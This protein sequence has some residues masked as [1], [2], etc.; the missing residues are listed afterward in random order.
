MNKQVRYYLS[1][2]ALGMGGSTI[3]LLMYIRY[4]FYDPM[5]QALGC[6][7]AQLGALTTISTVAGWVFT[8]PNGLMADKFDSKKLIILALMINSGCSFFFAT[9]MGSMGYTSA[10]ITWFG[11]SFSVGLGYWPSLMKFINTLAGPENAGKSFSTYYAIYGIFAACVNVVEI[12]VGNMVGFKGT[13]IVIGIVTLLCAVLDVFVL[14]NAEA[15]E[16]RIAAEQGGVPVEKLDDEPKKEKQKMSAADI[17]TMIKWPGFWYIGVIY[18]FTYTV[19][20]QISYYNP[21]LINVMGLDSTLSSTF[22]TIR[23]YLF[24]LWCPLGGILAD[25]VFKATW[26]AFIP[27]FAIS[28]V[29]LTGTLF[30]KEGMNPMIAAVYSLLPAIVIMPLYSITNSCLRELHINPAILGTTIAVSGLMGGPVDGLW[31]IIFGHWIDK[32]GN[33]GFTYIFMFLAADCILG[34][35]CALGIGHHD[36][37]CREGKR[38]QLLKGQERPEV[39]DW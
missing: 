17:I 6:T 38:V 31:P 3:W 24:M 15:R 7:N 34:I 11:L 29:L 30:F 8:V 23:T 20:A 27:L 18:L 22:S 21:W 9:T 33:Q 37:K 12:A 19:Y 39:I 5:L 26:K 16:K 2:L 1:L 14:E 32:F 4:V 25:K 28:F 35:I 10:L 13:V 36:K